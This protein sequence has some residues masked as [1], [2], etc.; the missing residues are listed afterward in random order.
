MKYFYSVVSQTVT[1]HTSL[2]YLQVNKIMKARV[3]G[4]IQQLKDNAVELILQEAAEAFAI[5]RTRGELKQE[6]PS[7]D[8]V[9]RAVSD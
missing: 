9:P 1:T 2:N 4:Q 3:R 5:E 7:I 6:F 8:D